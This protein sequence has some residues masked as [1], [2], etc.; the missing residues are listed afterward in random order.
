MTNSAAQQ[1]EH[2][3]VN[4]TTRW[5]NCPLQ[6]INQSIVRSVLCAK[7]EKKDVSTRCARPAAPALTSNLFIVP[8]H[9]FDVCDNTSRRPKS[10]WGVDFGFML[11]LNY[12]R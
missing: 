11:R 12:G 10:L 3:Y 9:A 5:D 8:S 2:E 6:V 7:R 1:R 4:T